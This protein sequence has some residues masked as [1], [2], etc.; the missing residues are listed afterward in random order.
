MWRINTLIGALLFSSIL[1]FLFNLH[2]VL[3]LFIVLFYV[4]GE[5]THP[6]YKTENLSF[7]GFS[8]IIPLVFLGYY[9]LSVVVFCGYYLSIWLRGADS[10]NWLEASWIR[11]AIT[12]TCIT[13]FW[14]IVDGVTTTHASFYQ[15]LVEFIRGIK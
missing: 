8:A 15:F 5:Y 2:F 9:E 7:W 13:Y 10:V 12:M 6:S 11:G 1:M 4:I 3:T 14:W